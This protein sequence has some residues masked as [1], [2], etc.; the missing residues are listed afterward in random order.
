MLL[1]KYFW[2]RD[3]GGSFLFTQALVPFGF[4]EWNIDLP[5]I[6]YFSQPNAV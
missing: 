1:L 3:F 4:M 2:A 5:L 6:L